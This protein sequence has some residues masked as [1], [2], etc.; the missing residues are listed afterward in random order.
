MLFIKEEERQLQTFYEQL[1]PP[2]IL[3][4]GVP[5]F[6]RFLRLIN[7]GQ[8]APTDLKEQDFEEPK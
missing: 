2:T 3:K 8:W 6:A 5:D 7:E 1:F 4:E